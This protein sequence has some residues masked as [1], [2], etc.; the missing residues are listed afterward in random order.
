[1]NILKVNEWIQVNKPAYT[2]TTTETTKITSN[3]IAPKTK[4][5][6]KNIIN[7]CIKKEGNE[8]D[9][10][11]IDVSNITDMSRLFWNMY[12]FNGNISNWN[13]S[14][15]TDMSYM[16]C[17]AK[18]FNGDISKWDVS[19]VTNM[20]RMFAEAKDFNQDISKWNVSKVTDMSSMFDCCF[21]FNGDISNWNV[22]NVKNMN[23]MFRSTRL[24]NCNISKW[25]VSNVET[26]RWMFENAEAFN[27]NLSKWNV[28]N[29][30]YYGL[31]FN[32][33]PHMTKNSYKRPKF[34]NPSDEWWNREINQVTPKS[35]LSEST[36]NK[37]LKL[38]TCDGV[39]QYENT[40]DIVPVTQETLP[41]LMPWLTENDIAYIEK[42]MKEKNMT[43]IYPTLADALKDGIK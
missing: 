16:F 3:G 38:I 32:K 1:M 6:L 31:I 9:L 20:Q 36:I 17:E 27:Q 25:D 19:N 15:V 22:S 4:E 33:C 43:W 23:S 14:N 41:Q 28:S 8:C 30:K 40:K 12:K 5:E 10:N 13:T 18:S 34:K 29:V 2:T 21:D 39:Y 11:D 26:M 7:E 37:I 24:F 35:D 42:I